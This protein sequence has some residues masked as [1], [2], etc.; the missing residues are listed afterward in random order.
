MW[1]MKS[2]TAW[3]ELLSNAYILDKSQ[4]TMEGQPTSG[5]VLPHLVLSYALVAS[6]IILLEAGDLQH[7][8]RVLHFHFAG[9]GN[10]ISPL[11]GDLR[12]GAA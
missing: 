5:R 7:G 1:S 9:E 3:K 10:T 6:C 12:D 2:R 11:P 8:V 4:S